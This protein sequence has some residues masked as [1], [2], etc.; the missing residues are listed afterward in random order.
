MANVKI[1]KFEKTFL[2]KPEGVPGQETA[3][4]VTCLP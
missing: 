3:W 1:R 4:L 2:Q